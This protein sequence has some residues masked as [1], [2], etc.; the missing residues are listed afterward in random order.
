MLHKSAIYEV[1]F[2][3]KNIINKV[4]SARVER[5]KDKKSAE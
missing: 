5:S 2:C 3:H 1:T 4:P